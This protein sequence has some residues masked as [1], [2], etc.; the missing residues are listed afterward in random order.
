MPSHGP[1]P[2]G[3]TAIPAWSVSSMEAVKPFTLLAILKHSLWGKPDGVLEGHLSSSLRGLCGE[4]RRSLASSAQRFHSGVRDTS[5]K[6]DLQPQSHLQTTSTP[7]WHLAGASQETSRRR[8]SLPS[9]PWIPDHQKWQDY[10]WWEFGAVCDTK[11][12]HWYRCGYKQRKCCDKASSPTSG[13][14][15]VASRE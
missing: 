2:A 5:R 1:C 10:E 12:G 8:S 9:C 13:S 3:L 15:S 4:P 6:R 14:G 7:S 11:V